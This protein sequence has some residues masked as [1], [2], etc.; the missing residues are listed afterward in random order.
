MPTG[1]KILT[2]IIISL[3]LS[4]CSLMN[5]KTTIT[6]PNGKV[7]EISSKSDALCIIEKKD[8]TKLTVDNRG[9]MSVIEA[10]LGLALTNTNINLGLSNKAQEVNN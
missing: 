8:G 3:C 2:I 7:W 1:I 6:D 9:K 10:A 5:V 4:G